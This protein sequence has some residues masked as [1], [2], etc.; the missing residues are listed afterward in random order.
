MLPLNVNDFLAEARKKP[1]PSND[2]LTRLFDRY[3]GEVPDPERAKPAFKEPER[4]KAEWVVA[5]ADLPYFKTLV[6]LR[7]DVAPN[8]TRAF[9]P[10]AALTGA[11]G[12]AAAMMSIG[13]PVAYDPLLSKYADYVKDQSPT[14]LET[15]LDRKPLLHDRSL[16]NPTQLAKIVGTLSAGAGSFGSPSLGTVALGWGTAAQF[17]ELHEELRLRT[18]LEM[19]ILGNVV[20]PPLNG[21]ILAA[22]AASGYHSPINDMQDMRRRFVAEQKS[23]EETTT[24][25]KEMEDFVKELTK[26]KGK[27]DESKKLIEETVKKYGLRR[28]A[29]TTPFDRYQLEKDDK[30]DPEKDKDA[31]LKKLRNEYLESQGGVSA[32]R[33]ADLLLR[34]LKAPTSRESST[35]TAA[36]CTSSGRRS[37]SRPRSRRPSPRRATR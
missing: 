1:T 21:G 24:I 19:E 20:C 32:D 27:S 34:E 7:V 3:K 13:V 15:P 8:L 6:Q 9:L 12:P 36:T 31:A 29:M 5:G 2:D 17:A 4:V 18:V 14:V 26:L 22:L 10:A 33:F 11:A 25:V 35:A 37:S 16:V 28:Y 23:I 30:F